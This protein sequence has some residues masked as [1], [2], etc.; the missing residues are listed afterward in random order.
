MRGELV[1]RLAT[2]TARCAIVDRL[3]LPASRVLPID[4][5]AVRVELLLI[6]LLYEP[7]LM[8]PLASVEFL[9]TLLQL[10]FHHSAALS[11]YRPPERQEL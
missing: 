8:G 7:L 4:V 1:P 2:V 3:L 11:M 5:E 6:V 9:L 10:R